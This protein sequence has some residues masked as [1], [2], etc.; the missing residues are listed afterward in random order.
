MSL[1]VNVEPEAIA[2]E[3][4]ADLTHFV[5]KAESNLRVFVEVNDRALAA[6]PAGVL[7]RSIGRARWAGH[8]DRRRRNQPRADHHACDCGCRRRQARPAAAQRRE[9]RGFLRHHHQRAAHIETTGASL[10]V[11]GIES[12]EDARWAR[13]TARDINLGVPGPLRDQYTAPHAPVPLIDVVPTDLDIATPVELLADHPRQKMSLAYLNRVAQMLAFSP[14]SSGTWPVFLTGFAR[15][16]QIPGEIA[17][18]GIPED[19]LLFVAFGTGLPPE[20]A[21]GVRGIRL[22][23]DD[24]LADERF[25]IVMSDQTAVVIVEAYSELCPT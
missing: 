15:D 24:P 3:C 11:E 1:F 5:A 13:S 22:R 23:L 19:C 16:G 10:L 12:E 7:P 17:E 14:R 9:P 8:R 6:D 2:A 4:P 21:A 20:P 25:L 18:H